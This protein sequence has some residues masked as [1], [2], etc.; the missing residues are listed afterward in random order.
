VIRINLLG[1]VHGAHAALFY[2]KKQGYGTLINNIS[3]GGWFPVPYAAGYS[4]SKFG[5]RGLSE[6]IRGELHAWPHIHVCDLFPAFLDTPGIQHAGNYTG[7][8]LKPAPPV[9]DPQRVAEAIV[10]LAVRPRNSKTVGGMASFLRLSHF[11]FPG[12]SRRIT[13]GLV[14]KYLKVADEAPET[15]GNLFEPLD[16]GTGVYGGWSLMMDR[17]AKKKLAGALLF[18]AIGVGL[19]LLGRRS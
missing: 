11:F 4:A 16:Y 14:E 7:K 3:V 15:S 1:Y 12:L 13:A 9:Y 10:S 8:L 2:F 5:L 17:P 19:V 18:T 6:A